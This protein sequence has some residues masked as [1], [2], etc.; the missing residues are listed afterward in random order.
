MSSEG[1]IPLAKK[2]AENNRTIIYDQRGT[3]LSGLNSVERSTVTMDLMVEDI[4][5]LRRHLGYQEWIVLGHSFGGMLA[6][7]YASKYP[8]RVSAMIQSSSGGMD[9]ALLSSI[10][11]AAGLSELQQDSLSFYNAKIAAGDSSY[12][13]RLKRGLLLAP[14]Y[15]FKQEYIP[16]IAERLTQ[17]NRRINSLVWQNLRAIEFDTKPVLRFFDKPT[18]IIHGEQ[19]IV[20]TDIAKTAHGVLPN[21]RASGIE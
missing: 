17:S 13:T 15:L 1:F 9:L 21:S 5:T 11:I 10:N 8:E 19:D 20:G 4:E 2:L 3:G 14:A 16:V 6:Y 12:E 7:Y 18:L